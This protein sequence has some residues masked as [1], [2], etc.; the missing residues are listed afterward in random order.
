MGHNAWLDVVRA[1][2]ILLVLVSHGRVFLAEIAPWTAALKV[3]GF[4]GV[5]LF[6][7]LSGF[8]IGRILLKLSGRLSWASL[9]QFLSRR[10]LRTLPNYYLFVLINLALALLLIR[11]AEL[12]GLGA[13]LVFAQNLFTA[14]PTFFPEAWSLSI[15]EL[16]Y[17]GFPV[18]AAVVA[19]V[20]RGSATDAMWL[21]GLA[22]LVLSTCG[23]LWVAA[24]PGLS[25]DEDLRKVAWLR[26]D[27]LMVGVLAA[28]YRGQGGRLLER[29][30]LRWVLLL[31]F[32][33]SAWW[34]GSASYAELDGSYWAKTLLFN[35]TSLGCL[36][37]ILIGLERR[38]PA[39][40]AGLAGFVARLSFSGYLV[41]LP[42][43]A[44]LVQY[45]PASPWLRWV[46]F[47]VLTAGLSW[48]VYHHWERRFLRLRDRLF[49]APR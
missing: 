22:V 37:L 3:G 13:Y 18:L 2:A 11:P 4:L 42:V 46:L 24:E 25:W 6:F 7:V 12:S 34:A 44:L 9:G 39:A 27:G 36:G 38:L 28:F 26:L 33:V 32:G 40:L 49:A 1:L 16:F 19:L 10:W 29:P 41:N 15:E 5:E 35:L 30:G 31:L 8:L 14:H 48:L 45:G 47:F 43:A 17:F 23:R 20:L 21:V